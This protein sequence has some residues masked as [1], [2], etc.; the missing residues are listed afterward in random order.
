MPKSLRQASYLQQRGSGIWYFRF[1]LPSK[2]QS[3]VGKVDI[4]LSLDTHEL[5]LAQEK[6]TALLPHVYSIKRLAKTMG[7]LTPEI[8]KKALDLYFTNLVEALERTNAPYL[9]NTGTAGT[10]FIGMLPQPSM[11]TSPNT[12]KSLYAFRSDQTKW[13]IQQNHHQKA[14]RQAGQYLEQVGGV[15]DKEAPL[16]QQLSLDILKLQAMYWEIMKAREDGDYR[17][18]REF[19]QYYTESG[20]SILRKNNDQ[21]KGPTLSAAWQAYYTEKS[22]GRPKAD[23]SPPTAQ[24]QQA[25]FDEL[26][27]IVGEIS[28]SAFTRD[29]VLDYL[30]KVARL[31]KNRTKT[32]AGK[33]FQ[34]LLL[35][36]IPE[37]QRPS[38]RT[39]AEKL[40]K[41]RAFLT[42]SRIAKKYLDFDPTEGIN[43]KTH[44]RSYAPFIQGDLTALFHSPQYLEK[45]H[46]HLWQYWAP[47]LALYTGARLNEIAQL[48]LP[49]VIREDGIWVFSFPDYGEDQKIK[50]QAGIRKV[51]VSK[52]LIDLGFLDYINYLRDRGEERVLPDLSKGT[53]SWGQKI[54]KWFNDTYK[55]QCGITPDPSGGRKVFHSFRHTAITKATSAGL[56]I[57]HCQQA[58]GHERSILGET[59]TYTHQY[60]VRVLVPVIDA[61]DFGLDHGS[62]QESWKSYVKYWKAM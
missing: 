61:L 52:T 50:T 15:P 49:D 30:D 37:S 22:T 7:E 53:R 12:Q 27:E 38:S 16:F 40:A 18:E 4:R 10:E 58:F 41:L 31:P 32:Y 17:T 39:V 57:Q 51:P 45:R 20:Y 1:K 35:L 46:R 19:I 44:S 14:S 48:R 54:S 36:D 42:W 43:V 33:E 23:W 9:R 55:D 11:I 26:I 21:P 5:S 47:L 2:L 24:G 8:T 34:E 28:I 25:M 56:P 29:L 60:P 6:I 59:A 13:A 62:Y 3:L